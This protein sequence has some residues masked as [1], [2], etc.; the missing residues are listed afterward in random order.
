MPGF[1][2]ALKTY[3]VTTIDLGYTQ[4]CENPR[5]TTID[6]SGFTQACK[7]LQGNNHTPTRICTRRDIL[8]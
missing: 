2:Q 5:V 3:R 8:L 6:M 4:A 1:T 7:N